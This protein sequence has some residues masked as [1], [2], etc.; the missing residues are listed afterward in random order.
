MP[1]DELGIAATRDER[2]I[3][4]AYAARLKTTRPEDDAAGFVRLREAYE[5]ALWLS[6]QPAGTMA[7]PDAA[8]D[9]PAGGAPRAADATADGPAAGLPATDPAATASIAS[10]IEPAGQA[11][12][13]AP[14][15]VEPAPDDAPA[16]RTV[17]WRDSAEPPGS[18]LAAERLQRAA[19]DAALPDEEVLQY[20]EQYGW[21][22]MPPGS[23]AAQAELLARVRTRVHFIQANQAAGLI[24]DALAAGEPRAVER[25]GLIARQSRWEPLDARELFKQVLA[26]RLRGHQPPQPGLAAAIADWADWRTAAGAPRPG[27]P[28]DAVMVC[29]QLA[30]I[31]RYPEA[32]PGALQ[33]GM[34]ALNWVAHAP[35]LEVDAL[36]AATVEHGWFELERDWSGW[37]QEWLGS[38]RARIYQVCARRMLQALDDGDRNGS[39]HA[40]IELFRQFG[41]EPAWRDPAARQEM[42]E[43]L[44]QQFHQHADWRPDLDYMTRLADWAGW[45]DVD[46]TPAPNGRGASQWLCRQLELEQRWQRWQR[47]ADSAQ[48][49]SSQ[50]DHRV[51]ASLMGRPGPW[52]RRWWS[53]SW[54]FQQSVRQT[55][56]EIA[57]HLPELHARLP[58][59][60]LAWW[61]RP[62]ASVWS[63]NPLAVV[64]CCVL[65]LAG[66]GLLARATGIGPGLSMLLCLAVVPVA[67]LAGSLVQQAW[68]RVLETGRSRWP[69]L[70]QAMRRGFRPVTGL[71]ACLVAA[72][73]LAGPLDDMLALGKGRSAFGLLVATYGSVFVFY[74]YRKQPAPSDPLA[75]G[76][77]IFRWWWLIWFAAALLRIVSGTH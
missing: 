15:M 47:L 62:R 2:A 66:G 49:G 51:F 14:A 74:R 48:P 65:A 10:I 3:R 64:L 19:H 55:L 24:W 38:A 21:L 18:R 52:R 43:L 60:A 35:E 71:V 54:P 68:L 33:L 22:T 17:F 13:A 29:L 30:L 8:A 32:D 36:L 39:E 50:Y 6:R 23:S 16:V 77:S 70:D 42:A 25:F 9:E 46:G 69:A 34:E 11:P 28:F 40:R 20:A 31:E 72:L 41:A 63:G 58:A 5:R 67:L 4:R 57:E 45:L 61:S 44:V 37:P 1:W 12:Q 56:A 73:L 75:G 76:G 26:H 7:D 53:L 27:I 59:E